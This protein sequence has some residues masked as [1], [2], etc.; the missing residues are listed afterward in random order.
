MILSKLQI[1][2]FW[3]YKFSNFSEDLKASFEDYIETLP[4]TRLIRNFQ[5]LGVSNVRRFGI[6][7]AVGPIIISVGVNSLNIFLSKQ[8]FWLSRS[9]AMLKCRQDGSSR[10]S[11]AFPKTW[12]LWFFQGFRRSAQTPSKSSKLM[13]IQGSLAALNL[14]W[15]FG[16]S[17]STKLKLTTKPN[18]GSQK[19]VQRLWGKFW[20]NAK[21]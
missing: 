15:T 6:V 16:S 10:F 20:E 7:N 8:F 13:I 11:I 12:K 5:R 9:T 18:C 3:N 14:A 2:T 19:E 1:H 17:G 21:G 4:K